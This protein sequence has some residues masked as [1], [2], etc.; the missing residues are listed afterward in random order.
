MFACVDFVWI[1]L[2]ACANRALQARTEWLR[3]QQASRNDTTYFD[4]NQAWSDD[5]A[6]GVQLA[7]PKAHTFGAPQTANNPAFKDLSTDEFTLASTE[8]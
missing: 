1:N 2:N 6:D 4:N 5:V 3:E 7:S 8:M